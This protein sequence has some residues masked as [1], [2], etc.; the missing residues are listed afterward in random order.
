M[1]D[2]NSDLEL[3]EYLLISQFIKKEKIMSQ[4][5]I[6]YHPRKSG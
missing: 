3:K 4:K 1:E 6:Y 5:A 2:N